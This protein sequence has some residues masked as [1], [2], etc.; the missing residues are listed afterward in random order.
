[1]ND[2]F[3]QALLDYYYYGRADSI[4]VLNQYRDEDAMVP[5]YLFRDFE[6]MPEL[7]KEALREVKG[8][9]IE[10]GAGAGSHQIWMQT[11]NIDCLAV[12]LSPGACKVMQL[13]G[14]NSVVHQDFWEFEGKGDTLLMMMN[15]MGIVGDLQGLRR[16][17]TKAESWLNPKG[18]ILFDSCDIAYVFD[19]LPLPDQ[20]Y[21]GEIEFQMMYKNTKGNW[22][23]WLYIDPVTLEFEARKLGWSF[24]MVS[25]DEQF[26]YLG[27]LERL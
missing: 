21:Y 12:E 4:K 17:L 24:H 5:E 13:R 25:Q 18:Q 14:V 6:G 22:F 16:F 3:G 9:V 1:M 27:R 23:K 7:E 15:G 11:R 8:K 2:P 10:F 26:Q 20:G 19:D